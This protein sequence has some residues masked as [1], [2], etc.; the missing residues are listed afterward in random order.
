MHGLIC[1][2][3]DYTPEAIKLS[4]S[5]IDEDGE[6]SDSE[7]EAFFLNGKGNKPKKQPKEPKVGRRKRGP[8][9]KD[10]LDRESSSE[11]TEEEPSPPKQGKNQ[12]NKGESK[13]PLCRSITDH[14]P[15]R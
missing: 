15:L 14:P 11:E 13:N 12:N 5:Q 8:K 3:A 2:F 4:K 9:A 10:T 6:A 1:I 7:A